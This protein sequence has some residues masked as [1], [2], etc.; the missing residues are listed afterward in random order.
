M[1]L[2]F[3]YTNSIY[4]IVFLI[5]LLL[6]LPQRL[7]DRTY[8]EVRTNCYDGSTGKVDVTFNSLNKCYEDLVSAVANKKSSSTTG[9]VIT[10]STTT[11]TASSVSG[12]STVSSGSDAV[13]VSTES[14]KPSDP[15]LSACKTPTSKPLAGSGST[16]MP[17]VSEEIVPS[18]ADD[19]SRCSIADTMEPNLLS[20]ST[21]S[22][23]SHTVY[24]KKSNTAETKPVARSSNPT[25][26][27]TTR[28]SVESSTVLDTSVNLPTS[29]SVPTITSSS[30]VQ[31]LSLIHI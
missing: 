9:A 3:C 19:G 15:I 16:A 12:V 4:I 7:E 25:K 2:Y 14:I 10:T 26:S 17:A 5:L 27:S 8:L 21:S 30:V 24:A 22:S 1:C 20:S 13:E 29:T 28:S 6:L 18:Q 23:T 11:S 31:Q